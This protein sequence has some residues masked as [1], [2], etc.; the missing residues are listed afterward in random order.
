MLKVLIVDDS[1]FMRKLLT[2]I[3]TTAGHTVVGE[4]ENAHAA[5]MLYPKLNPD[6]VTLDIVMPVIEN[7]TALHAV[8]KIMAFDKTAK[9]LMVTTMGQQEMITE[10]IQAG[11]K[12][13]LLKPFQPAHVIAAIEKI[14]R[15]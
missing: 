7:I 13:F 15:Q 4:A 2:D 6:L 5:V 1:L 14:M 8:E 12:D 11:A 10:F 3:L 9:I